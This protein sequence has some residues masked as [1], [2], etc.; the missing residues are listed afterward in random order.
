MRRTTFR[1]SLF[2][3][4][5]LGVPPGGNDATLLASNSILDRAYGKPAQTLNPGLSGR[6]ADELS[7]DELAAIIAAGKP[8]LAS[9]EH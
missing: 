2:H 6:S 3:V 8:D 9:T 5:S 4:L 7:D 1:R